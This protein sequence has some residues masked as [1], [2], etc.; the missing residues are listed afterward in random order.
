MI[1]IAIRHLKIAIRHPKISGLKISVHSLKIA[2][3]KI[4]AR[5]CVYVCAWVRGR[6]G[7]RMYSHLANISKIVQDA[8]R[9]KEHKHQSRSTRAGTQIKIKY[10]NAARSIGQ[11]CKKVKIFWN[12]RNL[13]YL[14]IVNQNTKSNDNN[15]NNARGRN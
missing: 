15:N 11:Q 13:L 9:A 12:Y 3:L 6:V 1:K 10:T 5:V 7:A 4:I 2:G 14:C 8:P